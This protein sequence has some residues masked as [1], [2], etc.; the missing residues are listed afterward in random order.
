[1]SDEETP[2]GEEAREPTT[3]LAVVEAPDFDAMTRDDA[4]AFAGSNYRIIREAKTYERGGEYSYFKDFAL[5]QRGLDSTAG[6]RLERHAVEWRVETRQRELRAMRAEDRD[7]EL[8]VTPSWRPGEGGYFAPPLWLIEAFADVPRAERVLGRLAPNFLLPRGPQ[9]INVPVLNAG[10]VEGTVLPDGAEPEGGITD[11]AILNPVVTISGTEDV[12]LAMLE[13]SQLGAPLDWVL[14]T[15]MKAAYEEKLE[16]QLLGGAGGTKGQIL[17]LLN[18]PGKN[19]IAYTSAKPEGTALYPLLGQALAQ[20]GNKRKVPPGAWLLN[21]SRLAWI[22]TSEDKQERPLLLSDYQG[23]FP[24][25]G[26][27][28]RPVY[29]DDAM[30]TI[31]G[32]QV[33]IIACV[34]SD[35]LVLESLPITNVYFQPLAGSMQARL[36]M[37]SYVAGVTARY[38]TGISVVSGTGLVPVAGF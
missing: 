6:E 18:V 8:R 27:I 9:S 33:P 22:S 23:D 2:A 21:T 34:P 37:R 4:I 25:A 38:P 14:F 31:E 10:V 30:P 13:Q 12:P 20:I 5:A 16:A 36:Q 26:M 17:G 32:G 29:L 11:S 35:I 19:E 7:Y 28:S 3:D 1:M 24:T 15:A